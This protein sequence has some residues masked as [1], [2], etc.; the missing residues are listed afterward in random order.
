[1]N[2]TI[3][4]NVFLVIKEALQN[5]IK[6]SGAKKVDIIMRKEADALSLTIKD[7]GKGIDFDNIRPYS[8]GLTNMKKRMEDVGI[9]FKIENDNGTL[10][11]LFR[12]TI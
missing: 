8:N 9:D 3:R 6:H 4:R 7:D 5:I 2:G 11:T 10:I 1:M 12:K